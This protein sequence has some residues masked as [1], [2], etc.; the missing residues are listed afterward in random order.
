[1]KHPC[2]LWS[3]LFFPATLLSPR[4]IVLDYDIKIQ[5]LRDIDQIFIGGAL[6]N[7][8]LAGFEMILQVSV[9]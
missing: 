1:M 9:F 3:L 6:G 4:S 2:N 5:R 7:F 8:S